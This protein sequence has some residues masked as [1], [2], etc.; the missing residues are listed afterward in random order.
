MVYNRCNHE[1][2]GSPTVTVGVNVDRKLSTEISL[3]KIILSEM[4]YENRFALE[5]SRWER[6]HTNPLSSNDNHNE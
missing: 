1:K 3:L 5:W 2:Q 6:K 4:Y